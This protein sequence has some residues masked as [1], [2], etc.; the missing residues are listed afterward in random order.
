MADDVS[1]AASPEPDATLT[2]GAKFFASVLESGCVETIDLKSSHADVDDFKGEAV[3]F[4]KIGRDSN[5][6]VDF[7]VQLGISQRCRTSSAQ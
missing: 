6:A 7:M 3:T 4:Q 1:K 5:T 2:E